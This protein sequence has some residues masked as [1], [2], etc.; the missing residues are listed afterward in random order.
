MKAV[1]VIDMP[2]GAEVE[3]YFMRYGLFSHKGDKPF[4]VG[5]VAFEC[6]N[7]DLRPLPEEFNNIGAYDDFQFGFIE[8]FNKCLEEITK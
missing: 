7:I 1:L 4:R 3:D 8:G 2:D 6:M 5:E